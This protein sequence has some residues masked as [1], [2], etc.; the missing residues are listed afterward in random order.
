MRLFT[1]A[2]DFLFSACG[3]HTRN[4][5]INELV[6]RFT[7][8]NPVLSRELQNSVATNTSMSTLEVA[9]GM[10]HAGRV[11]EKAILK[12]DETISQIKLLVISK[13]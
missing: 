5:V 8:C 13:Q 2:G 10:G 1:C 3:N 12:G 9:L 6:E 11:Q 4:T 7:F